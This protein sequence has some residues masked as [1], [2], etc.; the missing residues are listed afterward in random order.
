MAAV[1]GAVLEVAGQAVHR[2]VEAPRRGPWSPSGAHGDRRPGRASDGRSARPRHRRHHRG[3]TAARPPHGRRA[4]PRPA[5]GRSSPP[6][7][8]RPPPPGRSVRTMP[9]RRPRSGPAPPRRAQRGCERRCAGRGTGPPR[10]R[11][12]CGH[13]APLSEF[14][15]SWERI[16]LVHGGLV[17]AWHRVGVDVIVA[18]GPIYTPEETSAL[19]ACPLRRS[20][21]ES[22]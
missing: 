9:S 15:L 2:R 3:T 19:V 5:I 18:H 14:D 20:F 16:K 13:R 1:P 11:A 4:P 12:R 21:D 10:T 17:A 8:R 22:S 6:T 7:V